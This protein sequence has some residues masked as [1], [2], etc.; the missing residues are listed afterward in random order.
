MTANGWFQFAVFFAVLLA[1]MKP[2]G[3]YIANVLEGKKTFLDPVMKPVEGFIYRIGGVEADHEMDWREYAFALLIFSAVSMLLTYL[4]ERLQHFLPWNPQ[5]LIGVAADLAWNTAASFTTNTNWQSYTPESTMSYFTQMVTL[6]YHNFTSAACGIAVAITL[7]RGLFREGS[8]TIGNVWVDV[9]RGLLGIVLPLCVIMT[10]ILIQ[11]GVTQNL[12]AY[13]TATTLE[14][15]TQTI[16]QGPVASQEAIK[17][18][19][20]NGGGFF[21]A[22]SAHPFENPTPLTNFLE[23]LAIFLIPAALTVTLGK[24]SGSPGHGWAVFSTMTILFAIGL[25]TVYWAESQPHPLLHGITQQASAISPGGNMEGKETRFG[26]AGSSL[27]AVTTTDASCG[28]VNSMHDSFTPLG[29][30]VLLGN[31]LLGEII[32]GGVGAGLYGM[33]IF[34]VLSVFIAGLM[35]GRT[36][37]YLGKKIEAFDIKMSRSWRQRWALA[38]SATAARMASP[39]CS[40]PSLR[41]LA[42][43]VRLSRVSAQIP[44][45]S[46]TRWVSP[47]WLVAFS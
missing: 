45:G 30:M 4:I 38:H 43:T 46:T 11:Q 6:A 14:H 44:T 12:H 27:I 28:A 47:C 25:V 10:P 17:M 15:Q 8:K 29:G 16:A 3:L 1:L 33:L 34:V 7:I 23:I 41:L 39:R 2:L 42:T 9:T 22:N 32:F 35:V 21:N 31:I 5:H 18:L 26:I 20:T 37:E 24:L 40:T 13:T 19:G 36:P